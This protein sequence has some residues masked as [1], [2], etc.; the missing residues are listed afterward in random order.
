LDHEKF[1][2]FLHFEK[3][4][5]HFIHGAFPFPEFALLTSVCND[6]VRNPFRAASS[7][8]FLP[9]DL[10]SAAKPMRK[11]L[12]VSPV[13]LT[14]REYRAWGISSSDNISPR[15]LIFCRRKSLPAL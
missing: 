10:F 2:L 12:P 8:H 7:R 1:S 9:R 3:K 4:N 11:E 5:R 13:A 6:D 14:N 15:F